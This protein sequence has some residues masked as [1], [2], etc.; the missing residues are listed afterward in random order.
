MCKIITGAGISMFIIIIII[1]IIIEHTVWG[2][3][4]MT[5]A[6]STPMTTGSSTTWCDDMS[7]DEP[8]TG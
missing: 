5:S 2:Q 3:G 6:S 4:R 8:I 7:A 1:I